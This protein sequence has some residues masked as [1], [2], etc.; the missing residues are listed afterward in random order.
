MGW[1]TGELGVVEAWQQAVNASAVA[2]L[3]AASSPDIEVGGPRGSGHGHALLRE[4]LERA[5][6]H[7]RPLRWF[8]G[9]GGAVVV[10]Q[11]ARWSGGDPVRLA[12]SFRVAG[13]VV[14][15]FFRHDDLA[16]ALASAGLRLEDEVAAR[17]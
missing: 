12:S 1:R 10:E 17:Q 8:C 4:W 9:A 2:R 7:L 14:A 13:G 11:D 5:G 3:L 6:L 15:R 16:S